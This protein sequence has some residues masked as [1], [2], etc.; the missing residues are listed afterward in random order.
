[1]TGAV[2]SR[3]SGQ[4]LEPVDSLAFIG[5]NPLDAPNVFIATGDSGNGMTHG[6]IAGL[7]LRDL[8]LG[9]PNPWAELYDP[10]RKSLRAA[11]KWVREVARSSKPFA[12]WV[13]PAEIDS[14]DELKHGEAGVLRRGATFVAVRRD[15]SGQLVELSAVCPH[16][17]CIVGWNAGERTWDCPCHGS[18]FA[19]DGH[20]VNGPAKGGL[21]RIEEGDPVI[22]V[23]TSLGEV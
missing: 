20:V 7:L 9:R 18:R 12:R 22:P 15:E 13:Q 17:G 21:A 11:D 19:P 10:A 8:V 2:V 5:R 16:L 6:A 23:G 3:W 14:S 4:I 1:M